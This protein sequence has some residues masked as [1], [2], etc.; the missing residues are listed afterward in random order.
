MGAPSAWEVLGR[1]E[2]ERVGL[3]GG[4]RR[5]APGSAAGSL[6]APSSCSGNEAAVGREEARCPPWRRWRPILRPGALSSYGEPLRL[7]NPT[8]NPREARE[9]GMLLQSPR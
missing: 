3:R 8:L 4:Y 6:S 5:E 9:E 7:R 1:T 2:G